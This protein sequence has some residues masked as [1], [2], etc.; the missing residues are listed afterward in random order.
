MVSAPFQKVLLSKWQRLRTG[1]GFDAAVR[2]GREE[3]VKSSERQGRGG[4]PRL[5]YYVTYVNE[6]G[7]LCAHH[8]GEA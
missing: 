7:W 3:G 5:R 1:N 4:K 8:T 6:E 2:Y